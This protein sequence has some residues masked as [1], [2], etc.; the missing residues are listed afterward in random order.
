MQ[1]SEQP[2]ALYRYDP[3]RDALTVAACDF[4]GPNGLAFSPDG[5]KLYVAETGDQTKP[6]PAQFIRVFDV[7]EDGKLSGGEVFHKISPGYCD[8]LKVDAAGRVWSSA[9]DGVHCLTPAGELIGKIRIPYRVSNLCFGGRRAEPPVHR[10]LA[11]ALRHLPQ[12]ARRARLL[13]SRAC[14]STVCGC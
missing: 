1:A 7:G 2:P 9:A 4:D 6:D 8:G 11:H 13:R 14:G 12:H 10:R 5:R 3:A